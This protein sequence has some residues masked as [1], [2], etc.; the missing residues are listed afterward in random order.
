MVTTVGTVVTVTSPVISRCTGQGRRPSAVRLRRIQ[1]AGRPDVLDDLPA[2]P[3]PRR[4][5]TRL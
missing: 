4:D 5:D 1:L 2:R 3:G